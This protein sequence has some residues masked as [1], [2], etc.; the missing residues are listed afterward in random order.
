MPDLTSH[1]TTRVSS[2]A[3][4]WA[5]RGN[6]CGCCQPTADI[7]FLLRTETTTIP[8]PDGRPE[9]AIAFISDRSG[10]TALWLIDAFSAE[11]RPLQI[12]E[13]RY[14]KPHRDLDLRVVEEAGIEIPARI[15]ITDSLHR[16]YAPDDAWIHADDMLVA[17][18]Q[19][20]KHGFPQRRP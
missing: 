6:S 12:S 2:T 5:G 16:S 11:Q 4:T 3:V 20:I 7:R 1:L 10:N 19:T 18:R 13:R 9:A 17:E 14:L 8:T 15:G